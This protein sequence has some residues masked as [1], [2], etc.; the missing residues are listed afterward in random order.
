MNGAAIPQHLRTWIGDMVNGRTSV[1]V[2]HMMFSVRENFTNVIPE[3]ALYL[4]RNEPRIREWAADDKDRNE[5]IRQCV[6]DHARDYV[7]S[8]FFFATYPG[9]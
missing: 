7:Y 1:E 9:D 2:G 3:H 6:A 8:L 5:A 4:I